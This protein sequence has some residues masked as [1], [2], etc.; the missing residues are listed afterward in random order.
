MRIAFA[1]L[2]IQEPEK[3]QPASRKPESK[4]SRLLDAKR[5]RNGKK[6]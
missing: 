2:D 5:R 3:R 1:S 4:T 6:D